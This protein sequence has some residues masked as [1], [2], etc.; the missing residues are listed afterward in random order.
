MMIAI[1]NGTNR[2]E[3]KTIKISKTLIN[4]CNQRHLE[5]ALVTLENFTDLFRGDY[6]DMENANTEQKDDLNNIAKANIL[7]FV[8]PT[9]HHGIP[10]PLK[11]FLDIVGIKGLYAN[12]TIG[13]LSSNKKGWDGARHTREVINGIVAYNKEPNV[14]IIPEVP[15]IYSEDQDISRMEAFVDSLLEYAEKK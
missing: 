13:V 2:K 10:S 8:V 4:I 1:I 11:N 9:Y 3:N 5:T 12:S 7:I 14:Y 15:V 6:I